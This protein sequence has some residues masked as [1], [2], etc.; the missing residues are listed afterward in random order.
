MQV[1]VTS[2]VSIKRHI[3]VLLML[4]VCSNWRILTGVWNLHELK[5]HQI[6]GRHFLIKGGFSSKFGGLLRWL[7]SLKD[8]NFVY[9]GELPSKSKTPLLYMFILKSCIS[10]VGWKKK[11]FCCL[12]HIWIRVICF[13]LYILCIRVGVPLK[14]SNLFYSSQFKKNK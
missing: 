8:N 5:W 12:F 7:M 6:N 3:L 1:K 14:C 11:V 13:V 2:L 4:A 10:W 9:S